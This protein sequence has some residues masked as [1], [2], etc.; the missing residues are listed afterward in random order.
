MEEQRI[1]FSTARLAKEKGLTYKDAGQSYRSNGSFTYGRN[2]DEFYPAPS[3]SVLQ[4]W[5]REK[6]G[7]HISIKFS[8]CGFIIFVEKAKTS[9]TITYKMDDTYESALEAALIDALNLL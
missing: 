3:Q 8:N 5:L 6:H 1:N 9:H 7:I 2:D 4:K